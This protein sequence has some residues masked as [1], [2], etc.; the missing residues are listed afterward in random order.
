MVPSA[1]MS[2]HAGWAGTPSL[3]HDFPVLSQSNL[4]VLTLLRFW[5]DLAWLR[6][7]CV[8]SPITLIFARFC[9]ANCSTPGASLLQA[10]QCGAQNQTNIGFVP[11]NVVASATGLPVF[12]SVTF[13]AGN[14]LVTFLAAAVFFV[15]ADF[16]VVAV[17]AP[18]VSTWRIGEMRA[19][20][21]A[22][23][24]APRAAR[25]SRRRGFIVALIGLRGPATRKKKA[26][27][28]L[29]PR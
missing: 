10:G 11:S 2:I 29:S 14:G 19:T 18:A 4:T 15:G 17:A 27:F 12:T 25:P 3:V 1:A 22:A 8:P 5:K 13:M 24:V 21:K 6:S 28:T 7:S 20:S 16:L 9:R 23:T 26:H